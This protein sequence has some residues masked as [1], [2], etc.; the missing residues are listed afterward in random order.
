[1]GG[2]V[3]MFL[4]AVQCSMEWVEVWVAAVVKTREG[5]FG[6]EGVTGAVQGCG[7]LV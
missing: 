1:M 2:P 5:D 6:R 7:T 4:G 3:D